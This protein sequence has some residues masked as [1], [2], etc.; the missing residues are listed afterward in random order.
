MKSLLAAASVCAFGAL[1]L[2]SKAS[3]FKKPKH[4]RPIIIARRGSMGQF[5]ENSELAIRDAYATN[6]DFIELDL[7]ITKDGLVV[8]F[9]DDLLDYITNVGELLKF[10]DKKRFFLRNYSTYYFTLA[11]LK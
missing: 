8:L 10:H 1:A 6:V 2:E 5:P 9:H 4:N 3:Y 7:F 11:E